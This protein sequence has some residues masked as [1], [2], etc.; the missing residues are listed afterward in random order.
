MKV[1]KEDILFTSKSSPYGYFLR[2]IALLWYVVFI[3][4]FIS[5]CF[6]ENP[7]SKIDDIACL[8]IAT[9]VGMLCF[10]FF[11]PIYNRFIITKDELIIIKD[12]LIKKIDY[13]PCSTITDHT[14]ITEYQ[15][16]LHVE[17]CNLTIKQGFLYTD[18]TFLEL[19]KKT[20]EHLLKVNFLQLSDKPITDRPQKTITHKYEISI[21]NLLV[22]SYFCTSAAILIYFIFMKL[23]L[24]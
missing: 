9:I 7:A 6:E 13:I 15:H 4:L 11:M 18:Y 24:T 19:S 20:H 5:I 1:K 16:N 2:I 17:I 12:N 3:C 22:L 8:S 21:N 14:M 10:L 23:T